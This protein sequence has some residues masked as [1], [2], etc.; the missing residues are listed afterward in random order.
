[1]RIHRLIVPLSVVAALA[2]FGGSATQ[3]AAAATATPSATGSSVPGW[4]VI[5]SVGPEHGVT[6]PGALV[7]TGPKDAWST[8]SDCAPCSGPHQAAAHWI[9]HWACHR[10]YKVQIPSQL[11]RYVNTA[12]AIGA[13]SARDAWVFDGLQ[14]KGKALHWNGT[15]WAIVKIPA[16]VVRGN[17]S[18]TVSLDVTDVGQAGLWV[19]SLGQDSFTPVVSYAARY[20][21]GHWSKVA[22]PGIPVGVS[23]LSP[24]DIWAEFSPS[25]LPKQPRDFLA[26]WDGRRWHDLAIPAVTP[27][28]HAVEYADGLVATGARDLWLKR[29]I[30]VGSQ[31][32][33][34]LYL[35][36]WTGARWQRIK[37]GE[38][39]SGVDDMVRDGHGGLWL[40][41]NGPAPG[42]AWYFD[43]LSGGK[44]S[45]TALPVAAG[46]TAGQVLMMSWIPGTRSEWAAGNLYPAGSSEDVLGAIWKDGP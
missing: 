5:T 21:R 13:S 46:T 8:W 33:R 16:W 4:R 17:L 6:Y 2:T 42:Y 45:R 18:G 1:M 40:S 25:S 23:A 14:V 9:E 29:D 10:W 26:R 27:P 32:A 3:V 11:A 37:L 39:T 24:T 22:L 43:H 7:A 30:E 20:Y 31:G 44:W 28:A 36:H 12:V 19:F 35:L 34:T 38:P 41:V 15:R